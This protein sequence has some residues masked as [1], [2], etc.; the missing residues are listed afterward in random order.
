MRKKKLNRV[1]VA[2]IV[3]LAVAIA[4]WALAGSFWLAPGG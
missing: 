4:C 3:I 1:T 2:V